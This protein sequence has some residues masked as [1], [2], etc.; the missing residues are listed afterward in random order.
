MFFYSFFFF[1]SVTSNLHVIPCLYWIKMALLQVLCISTLGHWKPSENLN[2]KPDDRAT[3]WVLVLIISTTLKLLYKTFLVTE[4]EILYFFPSYY[5]C[6]CSTAKCTETKR[7]KKTEI[8]WA[9]S[10]WKPKLSVIL[11]HCP[12]L[13]YL[14]THCWVFPW[15]WKKRFLR[16][17]MWN[18]SITTVTFSLFFTVSHTFFFSFIH[19]CRSALPALIILNDYVV[20]I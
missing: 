7:K 1:L 3:V 9:D 18:L 12:Q 11:I 16:E 19:G 6:S 2:T 15:K 17:P 4:V 13:C 10:R 5:F 8:Q 20:S 14:K